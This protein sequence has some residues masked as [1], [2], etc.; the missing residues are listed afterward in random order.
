MAP[1][2][3]KTPK[4][5]IYDVNPANPRKKTEAH[6]VHFGHFWSL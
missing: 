6:V 2:E 4:N 5:L 1:T 3:F